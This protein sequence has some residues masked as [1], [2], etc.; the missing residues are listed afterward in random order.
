MAQSSRLT[1]AQWVDS[2]RARAIARGVSAAT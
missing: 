1:F 2:F